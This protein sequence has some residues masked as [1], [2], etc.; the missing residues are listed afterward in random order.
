M[1]CIVTRLEIFCIDIVPS[2][3]CSGTIL[4]IQARDCETVQHWNFPDGDFWWYLVCS[5]IPSLSLMHWIRHGPILKCGWCRP[6][7]RDFIIIHHFCGNI[8]KCMFH[9]W[10]LTGTW[11]WSKCILVFSK[12]Q[13]FG[14]VSVCNMLFVFSDHYDDKPIFPILEFLNGLH[15]S[16]WVS[17]SPGYWMVDFESINDDISVSSNLWILSALFCLWTD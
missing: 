7:C 10:H 9:C 17:I 4:P 16:W 12:I 1:I 13:L 5:L 11:C 6:R 15:R 14:W 2:L 8:T 3:L